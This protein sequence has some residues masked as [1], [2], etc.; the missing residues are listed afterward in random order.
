MANQCEIREKRL[1]WL[2]ISRQD[3]NR[4]TK[5]LAKIDEILKPTLATPY[6]I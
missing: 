5:V 1:Q 4:V 3:A 2:E 6:D